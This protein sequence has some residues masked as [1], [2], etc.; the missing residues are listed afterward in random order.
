M[1]FRR[2]QLPG[3][4]G[5]LALALEFERAPLKLLEHRTL[6]RDQGTVS[7]FSVIRHNQPRLERLKLIQDG[8]PSFHGRLFRH[9]GKELALHDV[10]GNQHAVLLNEDQHVPLG[11]RRSQAE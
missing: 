3:F 1:K 11:V 6:L 9:D 5:G 8:K 2:Q 7:E 10:S 4:F